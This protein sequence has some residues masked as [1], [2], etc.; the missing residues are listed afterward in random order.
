MCIAKVLNLEFMFCSFV[1]KHL[2]NCRLTKG[3]EF[4]KGNFGFF[5]FEK[6]NRKYFPN[7]NFL[8]ARVEIMIFFLKIEDIKI[9]F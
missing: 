6:K 8:E 4:L 5:N 9:S 2:T 1:E 3:Q 7:D